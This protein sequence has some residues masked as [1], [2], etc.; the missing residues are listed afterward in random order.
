MRRLAEMLAAQR[1]G[2]RQ[3]Y[4]GMAS[5]AWGTPAQQ[6]MGWDVLKMG[7]NAGA[8]IG[9]AFASGGLSKLLG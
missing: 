8:G 9:G 7:L 5:Q 6:G 4:T 3:G 1:A 2:V